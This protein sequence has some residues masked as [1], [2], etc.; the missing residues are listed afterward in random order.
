MFVLL[1]AVAFKLNSSL[2]ILISCSRPLGLVASY[3]VESPHLVD[4]IH[5]PAFLLVLNSI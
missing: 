5:F 4:R 1:D 2:V 3:I